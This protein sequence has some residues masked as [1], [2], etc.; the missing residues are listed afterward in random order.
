MSCNWFT[1]PPCTNNAIAAI[2]SSSCTGG[3]V[4]SR[5]M[6]APG[7]SSSPNPSGGVVSAMWMSPS[8]VFCRSSA[9]VAVGSR[10]DAEIAVR[11]TTYPPRPGG[12]WSAGTTVTCSTVPTWAPLAITFARAGRLSTLANSMSSA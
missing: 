7:A 11:T 5:P 10:T 4:W 3:R 1:A 9:M 6:V 2:V 12:A 8:T